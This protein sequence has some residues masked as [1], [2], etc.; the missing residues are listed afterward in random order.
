MSARKSGPDM[1]TIF[2]KFKD[3]DFTDFGKV[4]GK[5]AFGEVRDITYK[6]KPMA[7]KIIKR[8]N[9]ERSDE[10][11][12]YS[13][14]RGQNIIKITKTIQKN[15]KNEYYTLIIMEKAI[16]RDLGK[17]NEFY[18]KH[19]LLKTIYEPFKEKVGDNLLRFY[20]RQVINALLT[21][22][23]NYYVHFDIKPENLLILTNLVIKLSDF[24]IL[25]KVKNK[26]PR[27]PGGTQGYL[28]PEYFIDRNVSSEN[29]RKQD[30][31][32]LGSTFYYLKTGELFVKFKKY[33]DNKMNA[34]KIVDIIQ[35]RINQI[36]SDKL[37]DKDF[38]NLVIQ[39]IQY[40][41]KD[42][43]SFIKI[44]RNKWLN[45]DLKYLNETYTQFESDE[46][47]LIMEF[48]K[49][50]FFIDKERLNHNEIQK[51]IEK[52]KNLDKNK[53]QIKGSLVTG[54]NRPMKFI[55]KK[56]CF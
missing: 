6:N 55:F 10:D 5:G 3:E 43:P 42:R 21:L 48:Q 1:K 53:D 19:N 29:A 40:K 33:D 8:E 14:L 16:L 41:P 18:F 49:K 35:R 31:F 15:I 17:L 25:K 34:D 39:L 4:L 9:S 13:D 20:G 50:D 51:S 22:Y 23:L 46:E 54:A 24:S 36:H 26:D 27:I 7:G 56:K 2:G 32:A 11:K 37:N 12:S 44:Y 45:K 52:S 38:T 47:K 30:Y 28:T